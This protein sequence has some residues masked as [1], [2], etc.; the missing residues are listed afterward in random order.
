MAE[1][2][3]NEIPE[4][5]RIPDVIFI[6]GPREHNQETK[7]CKCGTDIKYISFSAHQKA[8]EEVREEC[9]KATCEFCRD[10]ENNEPAALRK[11]SERYWHNHHPFGWELCLAAAIRARKENQ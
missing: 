6:H 4:A 2:P 1:V 10:T 5:D 7:P 8:V 3:A 9:C 11:G